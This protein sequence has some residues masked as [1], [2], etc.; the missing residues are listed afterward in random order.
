[1][2]V[3]LDEHGFG[4]EWHTFM[5]DSYRGHHPRM[6]DYH[7]HDYY[8]ISL[9]LRGD[10]RVLLPGIAESST[11]PLIVLMRP[12]TPHFIVND[13]KTLYH[14]RNILFSGEFIANCIPEIHRLTASFK[15]SGALQRL[16]EREAL[17]YSE[18]IDKMERETDL[19]RIRLY[20]LM[21]LSLV[22][23]RSS[24]SGNAE[25][26][27]KYI[28]GALAYIAGH[29]A[30]KIIAADLAWHLGVGRTTL[31]TAFK[32]YTGTTL[33]SYI[34]QCRLKHAVELLRHGATEQQAAERCGFSDAGN[35]IRTF[36]RGFGVTPRQ[37][38]HTD[39][40]H[41]SPTRPVV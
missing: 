15:T 20:L 4:K 14:R 7:M 32:K 37:Y 30:E 6:T 10:V 23:D 29:Y 26:P 36:K 8:E 31:M 18:L 39:P 34:L 16:T 22:A 40:P 24:A 38:L 33:N 5:T 1:M 28:T 17:E 3:Y 19:F 2:A 41:G 27:P 25:E 13:P 9:I 35:L 21:L 11:E 12:R